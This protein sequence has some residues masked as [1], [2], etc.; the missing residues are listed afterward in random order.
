MRRWLIAMG[1][2]DEDVA[3]RRRRPSRVVR[4]FELNR[5]NQQPWHVAAVSVFTANANLADAG[6][7]VD[8][9]GLDV[10]AGKVANGALEDIFLEIAGGHYLRLA[11]LSQRAAA[12]APQAKMHTQQW[13][14]LLKR[15][16]SPG[17]LARV[18]D[19]TEAKSLEPAAIAITRTELQ[20]GGRQSD[21]RERGDLLGILRLVGLCLIQLSCEMALTERQR[22]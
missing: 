17:Q 14:A 6:Q 3:M 5:T 18:G 15:L 16:K 8:I 2:L 20:L 13:R 1:R 22:K 4:T 21:Q 7:I 9:V 12:I 11:N 19:A 10:G